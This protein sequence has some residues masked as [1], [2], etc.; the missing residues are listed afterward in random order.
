MSL[1]SRGGVSSPLTYAR[2]HEGNP[3]LRD[4]RSHPRRLL[5]EERPFRRRARAED[6]GRAERFGTLGPGAAGA[7]AG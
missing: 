1:D 7:R 3:Q 6:H 5:G 2:Y 4:L